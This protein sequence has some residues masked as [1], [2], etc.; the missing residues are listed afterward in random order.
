MVLHLFLLTYRCMISRMPMGDFFEV[1][2]KF[3]DVFNQL[4]LTDGEVG[5]LT[6]VVIMNAG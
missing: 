4:R 6:G 3:A 2:C 5:L 1:Q